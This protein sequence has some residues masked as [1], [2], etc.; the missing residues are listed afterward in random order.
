MNNLPIIELA[1]SL[2]LVY[3]IFS[4]V[5]SNIQELIAGVL[6]KSRG[7]FLKEAITKVFNDPDNKNWAE[8]IY[9]H[10]LISKLKRKPK[11]D[12]SYI[13]PDIFTNCLIDIITNEGRE[14]EF[15]S[16]E[17]DEVKYKDDLPGN[18]PLD[19]FKEG[20]KKLNT[21]D[22]KVLLESIL[23]DCSEISQLKEK[24]NNWY[25][26]Y[27]DRISG[28]YKRKTRLV[29]LIIATLVT[30]ILNIDTIGISKELWSNKVLRESVVIYAE[31]I[32]REGHNMYASVDT[33][34]GNNTMTLDKFKQ[35]VQDIDS[36]ITDIE[37]LDIPVGWEFDKTF[38]KTLKKNIDSY[39]LK[40]LGWIITI[41][42]LS[43]GAPFWF[44]ILSKLINIRNTGEPPKKQKDK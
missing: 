44:K 12:P 40:I 20:L 29:T 8:F 7:A 39:L 5:T 32:V 34:Q 4:I 21:S 14:I 13:S 25:N 16:K 2:I 15:D 18:N 43:L 10:P 28:W 9:S 3:F 23:I 27:M 24:I 33:V 11:S 17:K 38:G 31:N 36:L 19:N 30:L 26:D 41:F 6:M 35:D 1:I 37:A 42:A 22:V